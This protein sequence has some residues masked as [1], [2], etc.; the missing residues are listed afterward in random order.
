MPMPRRRVNFRRVLAVAFVLIVSVS[1][2]AQDLDSDGVPDAADNCPTI[3]NPAQGLS[4]PL[5]GSL[6]SGATV[7]PF[8]LTPDGERVVYVVDRDGDGLSELYAVSLRDRETVELSSGLPEDSDV[9]RFAISPDSQS[10]AFYAI[11]DGGTPGT[12]PHVLYS[13]SIAGAAP[14]VLAEGY[15]FGGPGFWTGALIF[16][17]DGATVVFDLDVVSN[18]D[19]QIFAVPVTGG[20]PVALTASSGEEGVRYVGRGSGIR[21]SPDGDSVL[22][23][24]QTSTEQGIYA[25]RSA[26]ARQFVSTTHSSSSRTFSSRPT[27][28]RALSGR[29]A[30]LPGQRTFGSR[31]RWRRRPP[32]SRELPSRRRSG[33]HPRQLDRRLPSQ[34]FPSRRSQRVRLRGR[35]RAGDPAQSDASRR[36]WGRL[37]ANHPPTVPASFT[38]PRSIRPT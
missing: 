2:P 12:G 25:V 28:R 14:A 27:E 18:L 1:A 26:A 19:F 5:T 17:P 6:P 36:R 35:K 10:V 30:G 3:A 34:A 4:L 9:E 24:G 33:D 23:E 21:I 31:G 7:W 37:C 16:T 22:F 29:F 38:W 13:V 15:G 20:T 32:P 11:E 8:E